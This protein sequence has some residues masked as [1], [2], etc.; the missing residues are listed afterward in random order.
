MRLLAGMAA[1]VLAAAATVPPD[2]VQQ[3]ETWRQKR[4]QRLKAD[5]GWLSVAGLFW[6][7][8]GA[9]TAGTAKDNSIVLPPGSAPDHIGVFELHGNKVVF[10]PAAGVPI[11]PARETELKPDTS[12]NP[13]AVAINDLT[14]FVIQRSDRYGIRLKDRNSPFRRNF[15]GLKWFP[16]RPEYRVEARFIAEPKKIPILNMVGQTDTEDSPGAVEFTLN[17][18]QLR[19]VALTE[20]DTLFFVFRDKTSGK[21]TYGASRMLNTPMPKDGRVVLDFNQA[22]NP[23]CAFTPY[24]TCPLPPHENRLPVAVEAGEM[25]YSDEH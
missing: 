3:M 18:Q 5:G 25:K 9:N 23:P 11:T 2:Y 19:M 17:G 14:L 15:T 6:L 8:E 24:A 12:G 20:E 1:V 21:T 16:I 7:N 4:E 22:Y 13:D 10:R